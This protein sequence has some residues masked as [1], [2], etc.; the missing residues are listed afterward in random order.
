MA[1]KVDIAYVGKLRVLSD[2]AAAIL[3]RFV[4]APDDELYG[5]EIIRETGISSSTLYPALRLLT[6]DRNY[7]TSR[8][9]A[10]DPVVAG[11]PQRRLYRLNGSA[12]AAA[13]SALDE[14]AQHRRRFSTPV[15]RSLRPGT[16]AR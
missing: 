1:A 6:E 5:F 14:Y 3:E 9:E 13:R 7:L 8:W 2:A 10:V 11:R 16:A 12:G 4:R 15:P